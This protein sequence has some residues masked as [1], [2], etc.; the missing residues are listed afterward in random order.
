[1]KLKIFPPWIIIRHF[2]LYAKAYIVDIME[3]FTFFQY[4]FDNIS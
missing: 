4:S 2:L 3:L 1:M